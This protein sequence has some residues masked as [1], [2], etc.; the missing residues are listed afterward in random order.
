MTEFESS[1]IE[2]LKTGSEEAVEELV[3]SY[4][5][6]TVRLI[7]T[8]LAN[9]MRRVRDEEDIALSAL[10]SFVRRA[11]NGEFPQLKTR[12]DLWKLLVTISLRKAAKHA[13][14]EKA[15]KRGGGLVSGE[16]VFGDQ[17]CGGLDEVARSEAPAPDE[18]LI[19]EETSQQILA[20][21]EGLNDP[22]L[23]DVALWTAQGTSATQLAEYLGCSP[24]TIER[25]LKML[26]TLARRW[27]EEADP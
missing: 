8:R 7:R 26:R 18:Q 16:S 23:M 24:R 13:G 5:E 4:Y 6:P 21:L 3:D 10:D 19:C 25:K 11:R 12:S 1:W 14:Q 17:P 9:R 27:A 22:V 20:F 15:L 2:R